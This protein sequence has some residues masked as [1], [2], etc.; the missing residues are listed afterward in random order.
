[1]EA[2]SMQRD[3]ANNILTQVAG[4]QSRMRES[5][6]ESEKR[7]HSMPRLNLDA[8]KK[9]GHFLPDVGVE[10]VDLPG[11]YYVEMKVKA[12]GNPTPQNIEEVKEM[13]A[14][15][16]EGNEPYQLWL[17][18]QKGTPSFSKRNGS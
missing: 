5:R 3:L 14:R 4:Q 15:L 6:E 9:A 16:I 2:R 10:E 8:K 13:N 7:F 12:I 18:S 11:K 1:M 17:S